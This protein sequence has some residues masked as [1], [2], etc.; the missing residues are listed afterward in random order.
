MKMEA[1]ARAAYGSESAADQKRKLAS[2]PGGSRSTSRWGMQTADKETLK[3]RIRLVLFV[4]FLVTLH[5]SAAI[6]GHQLILK[7]R[8]AEVSPMRGTIIG[9]LEMVFVAFLLAY[10]W[11]GYQRLNQRL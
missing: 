3:T 2:M 5:A 7:N 1:K 11:R 9:G 6:W 10:A 4:A 8:L